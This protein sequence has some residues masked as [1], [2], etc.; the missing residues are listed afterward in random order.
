M[1]TDK[2]KEEPPRCPQCAQPLH[3][4]PVIIDH[5]IQVGLACADHGVKSIAEP[6]DL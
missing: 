4:E 2:S 1:S 3:D 5:A 6:F